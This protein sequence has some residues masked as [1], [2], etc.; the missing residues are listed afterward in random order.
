MQVLEQAMLP[1]PLPQQ[2]PYPVTT[3][4]TVPS[5]GRDLRPERADV[6]RSEFPPE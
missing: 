1:D 2:L 3:F 6:D 5:C 4:T